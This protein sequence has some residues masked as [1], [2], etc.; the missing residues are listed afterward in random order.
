LILI[1]KIAV[2]ATNISNNLG[3]DSK[4]KGGTET[5]NGLVT[6][7]ATLDVNNGRVDAE[8]ARQAAAAAAAAAAGQ[9]ST[10]TENHYSGDKSD[11]DSDKDAAEDR[12]GNDKILWLITII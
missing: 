8:K 7:K 10:E 12:A 1:Q 11:T 6:P 4:R 9:D 5:T 2:A 3:V